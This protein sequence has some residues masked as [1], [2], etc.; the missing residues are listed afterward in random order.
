MSDINEKLSALYD[1]ELNTTEI[2][3]LIDI[4]SKNI[5]LQ[6]RLTILSVIGIAANNKPNKITQIRKKSNLNL[7]SN[8]WFSN[9]ITAAA[10]ILLTLI[11]INNYDFSRM[12]EDT[13]YSNQ[14]ASAISSKEAKSIVEQPEQY[15][16]DYIMRVINEPDFMNS[17]NSIDLRN[18]GYA[19]SI[20]NQGYSNGKENFKLKIEKNNFGLKQIRYWRH[21]KKMIYMTP[22]KDGRVLTIYGNI[23]LSTALTIAK[24]ID[25]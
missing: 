20:T 15:L 21:G 8:I 13:K 18:V 12:N 14:I 6:E 1:G 23:S 2:D 10:S 5:D 22:L 16:T 19:T 25:K 7:F 3:D 24:T 17:S 9:S 11:I 4:V